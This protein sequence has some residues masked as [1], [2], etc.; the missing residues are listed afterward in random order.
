MIKILKKVIVFTLIL[1]ILLNSYVYHKNYVYADVLV[2]TGLSIKMFACLLAA[3]GIYAASSI[4]YVALYNAAIDMYDNV[5][6]LGAM[7]KNLVINR[8]VPNVK[9]YYENIMEWMKSLDIGQYFDYIT[10]GTTEPIPVIGVPVPANDSE[11]RVK[12]TGDIQYFQ[13]GGTF[14]KAEQRSWVDEPC[15]DLFWKQDVNIGWEGLGVINSDEL[16]LKEIEYWDDFKVYEVYYYYDRYGTDISAWCELTVPLTY[17][18]VDTLPGEPI[19]V[20]LRKVKDIGIESTQIGVIVDGYYTGQYDTW[21]EYL[22][23][24]NSVDSVNYDWYERFIDE[25]NINYT[26]VITPDITL[27]YIPLE[28]VEEYPAIPGVDAPIDIPLNPSLPVDIPGDIIIDVPDE[29]VLD[30]PIPEDSVVPG[31]GLITRLLRYI[32]NAIKKG[33]LSPVNVLKEIAAAIYNVVRDIPGQ[34]VGG[35]E[36]IWSG[37]TTKVGEIADYVTA[38]PGHIT[39]VM[40]D[41]KVWFEGLL[42]P[43][44]EIDLEPLKVETIKEKFPFSLPWDM[45][46]IIE[47]L[48]AEPEVPR[49]EVAILGNEL[50][51]DF[52]VFEPLAKIVRWA[53]V[54]IFVVGLIKLYAM[55]LL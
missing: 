43:T 17:E 44:I 41:V 26:D 23:Y 19:D 34:I 52:S 16:V 28:E 24:L 48:A 8:I 50:V 45:Q 12:I 3:M 51:L 25:Y 40:D 18:P 29:A 47:E 27:D 1:V 6:Y 10:I 21:E 7:A 49:W 32:A 20:R 15:Y 4:D 39:G 2:L 11:I 13:I 53:V 33:I 46:R 54:I 9:G 55:I 42:I 36:G 5:K 38:I 37:V 31:L 30:E 14:L 35:I 22:E